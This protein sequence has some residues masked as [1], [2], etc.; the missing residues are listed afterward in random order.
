MQNDVRGDGLAEGR[1][2]VKR[3]SDSLAD[4]L[5]AWR[6]ARR[7]SQ[8]EAALKLQISKRTLENWEQSRREPRG[9]ALR[10]LRDTIK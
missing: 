2:P 9:L 1:R 4:Q 7:L 6:K 3:E 8:S 5:R 10:H